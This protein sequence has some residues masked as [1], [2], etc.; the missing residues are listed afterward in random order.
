[1]NW[2]ML[3]SLALKIL[4]ERA[5]AGFPFLKALLS[6]LGVDVEKAAEDDTSPITVGDAPDAVKDQL[7]KWLE[8]LQAKTNRRAVRWGIGLL[9]LY[10]PGI[11]DD[12]WDSLF[13]A[14]HV[15]K[16]L[17]DFTPTF[18]SVANDEAAILA[19]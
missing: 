18:G 2:A 1:V 13:K 8:D 9:I 11:A 19:S 14:G 3:I 4:K 17:S 6:W 5:E 7:V 12:L 15:G 10:V 16:P